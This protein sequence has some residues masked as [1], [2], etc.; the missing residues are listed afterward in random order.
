MIKLSK[1]CFSYFLENAI[2]VYVYKQFQI[3]IRGIVLKAAWARGDIQ[4]IK[5]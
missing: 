1:L 5:L 3:I 2:Q 4:Y